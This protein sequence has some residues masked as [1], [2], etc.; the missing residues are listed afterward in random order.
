MIDVTPTVKLYQINN[1]FII[2]T[3]GE[4]TVSNWR[5][6]APEMNLMVLSIILWLI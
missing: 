2:Y 3:I 6:M 4:Q 5:D 1:W